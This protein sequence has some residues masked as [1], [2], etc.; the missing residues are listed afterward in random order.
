MAGEIPGDTSAGPACG[1]QGPALRTARGTPAL[2]DPPSAVPPIPRA[3]A[4]ARPPP[5]TRRSGRLAFVA[6]AV[7]DSGAGVGSVPAL[8]AIAGQQ[9]TASSLAEASHTPAERAPACRASPQES[10]PDATAPAA[11]G[12]R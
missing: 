4:V 10:L 6:C 3:R 9:I 11:A 1:P 2:R 7:L 12:A 5:P 8:V